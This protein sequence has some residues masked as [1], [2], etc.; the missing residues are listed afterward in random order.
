MTENTMVLNVVPSNNIIT[1]TSNG[2]P[3]DVRQL[4]D[5]LNQ[6]YS[7]DWC[8]SKEK[9]RILNRIWVKL[10]KS[11]Q[12]KLSLTVNQ[13]ANMLPFSMDGNLKN[14]SQFF[15]QLQAGDRIE[16]YLYARICRELNLPRTNKLMPKEQ[17]FQLYLDKVV[18]K[19]LKKLLDYHISE[20]DFNQRIR[21][22]EIGYN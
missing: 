8:K 22:S 20:L 14:V 15:E 10:F 11:E 18:I 5:I 2:L 12:L 6:S 9:T 1:K 7:G 17:L 19:I 4:I 3:T 13:Y 16:P 21:G